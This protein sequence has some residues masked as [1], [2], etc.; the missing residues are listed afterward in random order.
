MMDV[1]RLLLGK[2]DDISVRIP[3]GAS[4]STGSAVS[5][6]PENS[7]CYVHVEPT[8]DGYGVQHHIHYENGTAEND[9]MTEVDEY[10]EEYAVIF[11]CYGETSYE[12]ARLIR[13]GLFS[14]QA[15]QLLSAKQVYFKVSTPPLSLAHELMNTIWVKRCDFTATFYA[16][17][18]TEVADAVQNI[19]QVNIT[20][21]LSDKFLSYGE[22]NERRS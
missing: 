7:V 9:G 8:D 19:E 4:S 1:A 3:Y 10:T 12:W 22:L 2:D 16:Y 21:G 5:H 20:I 15:K 11:S 17:V 14:L 13:D 6:N 18:R